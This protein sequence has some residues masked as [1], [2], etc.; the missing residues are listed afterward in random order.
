[1]HVFNVLAAN[2]K[3]QSQF[4]VFSWW[5]QWMPLKI[6]EILRV[7]LVRLLSHI[8]VDD[9]AV[10]TFTSL[11]CNREELGMIQNNVSMNKN[12]HQLFLTVLVCLHTLPKPSCSFDNDYHFFFDIRNNMLVPTELKCQRDVTAKFVIGKYSS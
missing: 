7:I 9:R 1:M 2:Q 10:N 11:Y 4:T 3:Q 8:L 12:S 6:L 5:T